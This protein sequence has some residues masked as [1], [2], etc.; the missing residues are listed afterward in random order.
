MTCSVLEA[1]SNIMNLRCTDIIKRRTAHVWLLPKI[2]YDAPQCTLKA[3]EVFCRFRIPVAYNGMRCMRVLWKCLQCSKKF[4][5][6]WH[7]GVNKIS[8]FRRLQRDREFWNITECLINHIA[9]VK[10]RIFVWGLT[11]NLAKIVIHWKRFEKF[12]IIIF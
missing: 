5:A 1:L 3:C 12:F 6:D 4:I 9:S 8:N 10:I 11:L 2:F 7:F